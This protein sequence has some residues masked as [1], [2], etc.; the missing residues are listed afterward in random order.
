MQIDTMSKSSR[1]EIVDQYPKTP[2]ENEI[3]VRSDSNISSISQNV[4]VHSEMDENG[5]GRSPHV[6]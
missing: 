2:R 1:N 6:L 3:F 4:E 5:R